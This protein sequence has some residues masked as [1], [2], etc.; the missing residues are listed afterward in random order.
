M[1]FARV[2]GTEVGVN[3]RFKVS[4]PITE[5]ALLFIKKHTAGSTV[6]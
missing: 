1:E 4:A 2:H 3:L 5:E 6:L